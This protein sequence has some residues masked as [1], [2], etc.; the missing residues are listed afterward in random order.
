MLFDQCQNFNVEPQQL[1]SVEDRLIFEQ[2]IKLVIA[3]PYIPSAP[4]GPAAWPFTLPLSF[5][6]FFLQRR[7]ST[8]F[9]SLVG[10]SAVLG[11]MESRQDYIV[12]V[13]YNFYRVIGCLC[14][15]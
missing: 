15:V 3:V 2:L 9:V 8:L 13:L 4:F 7:G 11:S 10:E 6:S 1:F 12:M 14:D 5:I